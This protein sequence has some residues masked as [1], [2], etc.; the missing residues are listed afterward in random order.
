MKR[1]FPPGAHLKGGRN[2]APVLV[3]LAREFYAPIIPIVQE[4]HKQG[5]SLR[6]I[7]RELERRQIKPRIGGPVGGPGGG[8]RWAAA[9]VRRVLL[10]AAKPASLAAAPAKASTPPTQAPTV[11]RPAVPNI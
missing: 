1:A 7:G 5:L 3:E 8:S 11:Q 10:Y 9:Q 2:A 6:E 4:L